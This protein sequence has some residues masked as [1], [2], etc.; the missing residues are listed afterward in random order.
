VRADAS[1]AT[2]SREERASASPA[3]KTSLWF[4]Q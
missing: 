2:A 1:C 3:M 4:I